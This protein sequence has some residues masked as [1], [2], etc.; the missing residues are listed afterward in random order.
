MIPSGGDLG[1]ELPAQPDHLAPPLGIIA[2]GDFA[3]FPLKLLQFVDLPGE[4]YAVGHIGS[5]HL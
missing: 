2:R 4:C 3:D 5:P 1:R